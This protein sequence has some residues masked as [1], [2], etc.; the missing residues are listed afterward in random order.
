VALDAVGRQGTEPAAADP[1]PS[2]HGDAAWREACAEQYRTWS[3]ADGTVVRNGKPER[4]RCP[5]KLIN[6]EWV[7]P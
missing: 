3:E 2:S 6:G 4:V 7:I 5:L 1:T